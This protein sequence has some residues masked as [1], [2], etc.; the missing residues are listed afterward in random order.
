MNMSG[1]RNFLILSLISVFW[2]G[3][4][5]SKKINSG[6]MAFDRK[7]YAVAVEMLLEEYEN[8]SS[9]NDK[10]RKAYFLGK[11]YEYLKEDKDALY[12]FEQAVRLDY[13]IEAIRDIAYSYKN[14][15]EYRKAI[16]SFENLQT[17]V[18]FRP[19]IS[20]EISIC[21]EAINWIQKKD[22]A[23][24]INRSLAN[25]TQADYGP[26]VYEDNYIV[27]TSD[28]GQST[29]EAI[30]N[31]TGNKFSDFYIMSKDGD[32]V[33]PFDGTFNTEHN[34]GTIAFSQDY[35]EVYFTRCY[36]ESTGD[37]F[38]KIMYSN[39]YEG[40]WSD[41]IPLD[42]TDG[43]SNYGHPTLIEND[44]VLIFS[45][46]GD[47]NVIDYDLFYAVRQEDGYWSEPLKMPDIINTKGNEM[48]PTGDGDTLYFSSNFHPGLGGMDIFKTY[49]DENNKWVKPLRMPVPVNSPADD[50]GFIVDRSESPQR[51]I[52]EVGY[53]SSSRSGVGDDDLYRYEKI[54]V[55][56]PIK[57]P[58]VVI[59][60]PEVKPERKISYYVA[61][62]V[63][64]PV[65]EE[66]NNP[67][68]KVV[69][70]RPLDQ[71][72]VRLSADTN[73]IATYFTDRSGSFLEEIKS[74]TDYEV[75]A[76]KNRYLNKSV[77]FSTRDIDVGEDEDVV[78]INVEVI[79]EKIFIDREIV[80]SDI[81]YDLDKA[82]IREDAKPTLNSLVKIM[83]DN[84]DI[85]IQL[86]SHTDCRADDDYNLDLSQRRAISAVLYMIE[87]GIDK[88]RLVPKGYGET[89]LAIDCICEECTEEQHQ[90]NRRTTFKIIL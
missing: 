62:R 75:F 14:N 45:A 38:C 74:N 29:G 16:A 72:R 9:K 15:G 19:E 30:Y 71:V 79:L 20:R 76:G 54:K 55:E 69:G 28:R 24:I 37:A 70:Y 78:T 51:N 21:K 52:I 58:E 3:C 40:N 73:I 32:I 84:P 59:E 18:G 4:S 25:S 57:E 36:S 60:E 89:Q 12:W 66:Q 11:S 7:Q 44:S 33:E 6:E 88:Q 8:Q 50:F 67:N 77:L 65:Y 5:L 41:P 53:F 2:F 48:F 31:W 83:L 39:R 13:G 64:E 68:S 85:R 35:N 23:Y 49:L 63:V 26:V 17:T 34:E 81:Y 46:R 82:E 80:L 10:A 56:K 86:S 42:F 90:I 47:N 61:G 22:E 1:L 87:N 27:F 43:N